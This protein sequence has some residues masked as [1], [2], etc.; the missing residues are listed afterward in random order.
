MS[1]SARPD[2]KE[3][4]IWG[5]GQPSPDGIPPNRWPD[6]LP[7]T[8]PILTRL[9]A[10][11][12]QLGWS[13]LRAFAAALN[14]PQDAFVR[15]VDRPISRGSM[16]YY[17]PQPPDMGAEQFGVSSHTDYGCLTLLYQD[18]TGGLQVQG[19][20]GTWLMAHP[21]ACSPGSRWPGRMRPGARG[22][23]SPAL[24]LPRR[25][26]MLASVQDAARYRSNI[27]HA[28]PACA[29]MAAVGGFWFAAAFPVM[30]AAASA[31][32]QERPPSTDRTW[33]VIQFACSLARNN[34]ALAMSS[35]LPMRL[36][37]KPSTSLRWP[38]GP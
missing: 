34:V 26:R 37:C 22:R 24:R 12:N 8:R 4:F 5:L 36:V 18:S 25:C 16:I 9:F 2:L 7:E 3:S 17:P 15:T 19:S 6:F 32:V 14:I 23:G 27:Q 30:T 28:M 1:T 29:V 20:D 13:M 11:G 35:G 10:A 31:V 21:I 38:S 33:P